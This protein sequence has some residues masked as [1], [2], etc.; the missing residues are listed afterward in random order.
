VCIRRTDGPALR[1]GEGA[2]QG[3]S[4]DGRWAL[5]ILY[6]A[7]PQLV[8]LPTGPGEPGTIAREGI[9]EYV[10]ARWTPDGKR[11]V[12]IG[13]QRG[14]SARCYVQELAGGAPKK[15]TSEDVEMRGLPVSPDGRWVACVRS[16]R[17]TVL[18]PLEGGEPRPVVGVEPGEV[19]IRWSGDGASLFVYKAGQLPAC[20]YRVSLETGQRELW[21]ELIPADL[22]GVL[23]IGQ[24]RLTPDGKSCVYSFKRTLSELYLVEGQT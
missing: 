5:A 24:I 12:F 15:I 16:D 18:F 17:K 1:L 3:L 6:G 9:E 13:K 10:L 20:I 23:S 2:A 11:I 4:P 14:E 21:M 19:L 22:A 7:S 8:L